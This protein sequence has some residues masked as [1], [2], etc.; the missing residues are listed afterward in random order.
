MNLESECDIPSEDSVVNEV[1]VN[2]PNDNPLS[3]NK[4][5]VKDSDFINFKWRVFKSAVVKQSKKY[6]YK[7]Q[8][9]RSLNHD[10]SPDHNND[11]D[12][13]PKYED[14]FDARQDK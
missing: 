13:R 1:K 7:I 6:R 10:S 14:T 8:A 9:F 11:Q 3:Y 5:N 12:K 4:G 2:L